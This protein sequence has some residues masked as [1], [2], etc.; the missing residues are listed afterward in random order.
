MRE[1]RVRGVML[2]D[3]VCGHAIFAERERRAFDLLV[4]SGECGLTF[5]PGSLG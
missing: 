4:S 3:R 1:R 5:E 2:C